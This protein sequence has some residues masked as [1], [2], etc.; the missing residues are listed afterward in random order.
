MSSSHDELDSKSTIPESEKVASANEENHD[1]MQQ[2]PESDARAMLRGG[3]IAAMLQSKGPIVK[4]VLLRHIRLDGKDVKPHAHLDVK[5]PP[6]QQQEQHQQEETNHNH[7]PVL[8]ELVEEIQVDTTPA[9]NHVSEVLGGS[10]TFLGQWPSE[11]TVAMVRKDC[12][13]DLPA[14]LPRLSTRTLQKHCRQLGIDTT[15]MVEKSELV[16][17][18]EDRQNNADPLNPHQLQPPLH[19][20]KPRGDI[21]IMKVAETKEEDDEDDEDKES[22]FEIMSNDDFFLNYTREEYLHFAS[23]T[24][25]VEHEQEQLDDVEESVEGEAEAA[26]DELEDGDDEE[27]D[28]DDEDDD[29][30]DENFQLE[31]C[32]DSDKHVLLNI[33]LGGVIQKFREDNGRG[34]NTEEVLELRNAVAAELDVE[35]PAVP[36]DNNDNAAAGDRKRSNQGEQST[37]TADSR[38]S[39]R[40]KFAAECNS[41]PEQDE[42]EKGELCGDNASTPA[43]EGA[44]IANSDN[45]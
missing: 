22:E 34:P 30:D 32:E 37:D 17:A 33:I 40:V 5:H 4:A 14:D 3:D 24:D 29:G 18:L 41:Q 43:V 13:A 44:S 21:L 38:P 19:N 36:V 27:D 26:N 20:L 25:I 10:F 35:V 28:R 8:E 23:R 6:Q 9:R 39:K 12:L 15:S 2:K 16:A 42:S 11:G 1:D 31:E 7:R 45:S